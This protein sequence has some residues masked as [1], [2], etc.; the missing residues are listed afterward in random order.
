M[1]RLQSPYVKR[2]F[3]ED[4]VDARVPEADEILQEIHNLVAMSNYTRE[5]ILKMPPWERKY[6][7]RLVLRDVRRQNQ[8]PDVS[9]QQGVEQYVRERVAAR[10]A[11]EGGE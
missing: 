4:L 5:D 1:R 7:V 10:K 6:I 8:D 2:S 9:D 11:R 3:V